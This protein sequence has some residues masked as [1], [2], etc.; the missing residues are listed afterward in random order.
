MMSY[1]GAS[2][3]RQKEAIATEDPRVLILTGAG[4]G[5]QNSCK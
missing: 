1:P 4:S 3:D 5:K 2:N